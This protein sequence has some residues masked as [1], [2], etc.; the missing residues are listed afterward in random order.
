MEQSSKLPAR[1]THFPLC[2]EPQELSPHGE[3]WTD[4]SRHPL[5]TEHSR[6]DSTFHLFLIWLFLNRGGF[7]Q[8][9]LLKQSRLTEED[10]KES[11]RKPCAF[12]GCWVFLWRRMN[13]RRIGSRRPFKEGVRVLSHLA[14]PMGWTCDV[15]LCLQGSESHWGG[16]SAE[17]AVCW[18]GLPW[19]S[20]VVWRAWSHFLLRFTGKREMLIG[21]KVMSRSSQ[22]LWISVFTVLFFSR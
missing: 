5:P 21:G 14:L 16:G 7:F 3:E 19:E 15:P 22:V 12:L 2:L 8:V 13:Q 9:F 17:Q 20:K 4:V 1:T 10:H 11:M 6:D 18:A